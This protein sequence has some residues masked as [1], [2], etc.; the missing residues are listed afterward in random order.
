MEYMLVLALSLI[1]GVSI[2]LPY[3]GLIETFMDEGDD[4]V[5]VLYKDDSSVLVVYIN[6]SVE[7]VLDSC[8]KLLR[9]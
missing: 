7:E 9:S 3:T 4:Y 5:M 8:L 2:L 6:G 1:I